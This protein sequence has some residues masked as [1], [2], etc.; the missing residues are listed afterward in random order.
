MQTRRPGSA[1]IIRTETANVRKRILVLSAAAAIALTAAMVW[2]LSRERQVTPI[3]NDTRIAVNFLLGTCQGSA[4]NL[5]A[6]AELARQQNWISMLDPAFPENDP[7]KVVGMWRVNQNGLSYVVTT[8]TGPNN[9]TACQVQFD[10]PK[11]GR[12]HF[13][14]AVSDALMLKIVGDFPGPDWHMEMYQIKNLAPNNVV[15]LFVS[16]SDGAVYH[17]SVMGN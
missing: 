7:L 12:D 17:A 3:P 11:P 1:P 10:D 5:P 6:V 13:L 8:G 2:G 14:A 15:L 4:H 16:S 9:H